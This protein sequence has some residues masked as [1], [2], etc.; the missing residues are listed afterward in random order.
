MYRPQALAAAVSLCRSAS[1]GDFT[2]IEELAKLWLLSQTLQV[3]ISP[4]GVVVIEARR[5][6]LMKRLDGKVKLLS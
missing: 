3:S 2:A 6:R 5:E 1:Q 4:Q